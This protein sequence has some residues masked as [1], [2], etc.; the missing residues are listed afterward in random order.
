[1]K[2]LGLILCIVALRATSSMA[3]LCP[4]GGIDFL[5]AV[6]FDPSWIYG[7][8][9]GTSCN[10]GVAFDN[11]TTCL[12]I[13]LLDLCAPAPSCG[14]AT[15]ASNV[16][17]KFF[18][19]ASTA[20][21]SCFQN[22]SLVIG[23]QVFSGGPLCGTLTQIGCA[24]SGGPSSGVQVNLTGLIPGNLYYFRVFGSATP[25][26]QR[27]GLYCFCGTTGL[28]NVI[29]PVVT[30]D[31][32]AVVASSKIQLSWTT[33]YELDNRYFEI[34]RSY[35]GNNFTPLSRISSNGASMTEHDYQY[36]DDNA[37]S[38][39]NYYRLKQVDG[40]GKYTYSGV[41]LVKSGF[42][43]SF[44]VLTD[45]VTRSLKI[46]VAA[47]TDMAIY[48]ASGILQ[49][50]LYLLAGS[51]TISTAQFASGIYFIRAKGNSET[52]KFYVVNGQW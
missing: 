34:E 46:T 24:V 44:T 21:I 31:F 30:K 3:Q 49:Q 14:T 6:T 2:R 26:S 35:D 16:W 36:T 7:C 15:N 39:N 48:N 1:M 19:M 9:T 8:N 51:H 42:V 52:K 12:P 17:Y 41:I 32:K 29:L 11:R 43:Q 13:T 10:G 28:S 25:V 37:V 40:N 33:T 22:T 18:P 4:G 50:R 38:G 5:S 45:P 27:T 47:N 20:T 23:V